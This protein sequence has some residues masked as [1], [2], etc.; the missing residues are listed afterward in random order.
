MP[1]YSLHTFFK[2]DLYLYIFLTVW[3]SH[4]VLCC[5]IQLGPPPPPFRYFSLFFC[6]RYFVC[7]SPPIEFTPRTHTT[8]SMQIDAQR[9]STPPIKNPLTDCSFVPGGRRYKS[10]CNKR[11]EGR[12]CNKK[13]VKGTVSQEVSWWG[14]ATKGQGRGCN[15]IKMLKG[16]CYKR[17]H[18][19]VLH[20]K[21]REEDAIK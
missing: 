13:N 2:T 10:D 18:R 5:I 19:E 12:G 20:Q 17:C 6:C 14:F 3:Q 4:N 7:G 1:L 16:Q 8:R 15:K 21:G 11:R 9:I